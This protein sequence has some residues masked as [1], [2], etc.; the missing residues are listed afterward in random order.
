MKE[1]FL[2]TKVSRSVYKNKNLNHKKNLEILLM[3]REE[4]QFFIDLLLMNPTKDILW[5]FNEMIRNGNFPIDNKRKLFF[6]IDLWEPIIM[7]LLA[8]VKEQIVI[9]RLKE[10]H[11]NLKNQKVTEQFD[12]IENPIKEL[13]L[14]NWRM[15]TLPESICKLKNLETLAIYASEDYDTQLPLSS[16]PKSIGDLSNLT[17]LAIQYTNFHKLPESIGKLINLKRLELEMNGIST[18]PE[19]IGKLKNLEYLSVSA[20]N[21]DTLP[22][23]IGQ[24]K[25]LKELHIAGNQI[26]TIPESIGTL[27]SLH[28]LDLSENYDLINLPDS[29]IQ[30][31][32]ENC[33]LDD[34]IKFTLEQEEWFN[35]I[36]NFGF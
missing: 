34:E 9:D 32:L 8:K 30:L 3:L 12:K 19:N 25:S 5:E 23:S 14:Y 4:E 27:I 26:E 17:N 16:L 22:E 20:N 13:Y 36:D 1:L 24:L 21:L 15:E 2:I 29:I 7:D 35:N 18:L 31:N 11:E 10:L 28:T 6:K 33:L